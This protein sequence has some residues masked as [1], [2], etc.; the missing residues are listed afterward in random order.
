M[1]K[2]DSPFVS[3]LNLSFSAL[4]LFLMSSPCFA[5]GNKSTIEIQKGSAGMIGYG[6]LMA[7]KS[8]EQTLGRSYQGPIYQVHLQEY[9]RGWA[10]LRPFKDPQ[11]GSAETPQIDAHFLQNK[12]PVPICGMVSLNIYPQKESRINCILYRIDEG[13]LLKFDKRERGYQRVDVTDKIEEYRITGGRVY[14]Y[15]GP[16]DQPL[17]AAS[18]PGK[19]IIVREYVEQVT[20]ACDG[21]GRGFRA[22]F[23]RSTR[24]YAYPIV[25]F[26]QIVWKKVR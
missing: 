8:M 25:P 19:Y 15:V 7:L 6:T 23:D 4:L 9:I 1:N 12:N 16:A 20:G 26:A 5:A 3:F 13:D 2:S 22:E 18:G 24:P 11:A 10:L 21:I 14:V 17:G